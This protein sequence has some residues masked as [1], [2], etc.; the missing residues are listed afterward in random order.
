MIRDLKSGFEEE[1][2]HDETLMLTIGFRIDTTHELIAPEDRMHEIAVFSLW[3][4][5][6]TFKGIFESE[7]T[8]SSFALDDHIVEW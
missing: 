2:I 1:L 6:I 5:H 3:R 7:E 8:V 4:G